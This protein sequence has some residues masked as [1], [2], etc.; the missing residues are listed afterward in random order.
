MKTAG[1]TRDHIICRLMLRQQLRYL[2]FYHRTMQ[3]DT[4]TQKVSQNTSIKPNLF[5]SPSE[6]NSSIG[7]VPTLLQENFSSGN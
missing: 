5:Q 6:G 7:A 2:L 3:F 4:K 1:N